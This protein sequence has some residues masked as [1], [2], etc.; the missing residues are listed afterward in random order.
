MM[1]RTISHFFSEVQEKKG[2]IVFLRQGKTNPKLILFQHLLNSRAPQNATLLQIINSKSVLPTVHLPN[3]HEDI[4]L[5]FPGI[6]SQEAF[7]DW[8]ART[9]STSTSRLRPSLLKSRACGSRRISSKE[10]W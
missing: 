4:Y 1:H 2:T 7:A 8:V 5:G 6:D 3:K 10:A 9:I